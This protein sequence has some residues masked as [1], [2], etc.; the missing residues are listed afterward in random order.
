[1]RARRA[2]RVFRR[3]RLRPCMSVI[4][5][6]HNLPDFPSGRLHHAGCRHRQRAHTAA[7]IPHRPADH[8]GVVH[9]RRQVRGLCAR[10]R[11]GGAAR[12]GGGG[13]GARQLR[14]V[15]TWLHGRGCMVA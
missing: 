3:P 5:H 6:Q 4:L 2:S 15:I 9:E 13:G 10:A 1:M 14:L 8:A 12:H 7:V 11:A